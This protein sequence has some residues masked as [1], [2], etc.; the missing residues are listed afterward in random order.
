ML[1][2]LPCHL[3][4]VFSLLTHHQGSCVLGALITGSKDAKRLLIPRSSGWIYVLACLC[5]FILQSIGWLSKKSKSLVHS[6]S[7]EVNDALWRLPAPT[8]TSESSQSWASKNF[9]SS[10]LK[11]LWRRMLREEG[12][13]ADYRV[14]LHFTSALGNW[15]A[16]GRTIPLYLFTYLYIYFLSF[17]F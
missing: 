10:W 12:N 17:F 16:L 13:W 3:P 4:V 15:L 11:G 6:A 5:S 2:N 8:G 9:S 1:T 7:W 14:G